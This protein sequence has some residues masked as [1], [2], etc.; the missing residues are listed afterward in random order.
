MS[1]TSGKMRSLVCVLAALACVCALTHAA[2]MMSEHAIMNANLRAA[3]SAPQ[4]DGR[5]DP[6]EF[7]I[8]P[9]DLND[10]SSDPEFA[11]MDREAAQAEASGEVESADID[12]ALGGAGA[13]GGGGR[14][15]QASGIDG[16]SLA[17]AL[18]GLDGEAS[19]ADDDEQE[20]VSDAASNNLPQPA[21]SPIGGVSASGANAAHIAMGVHGNAR[22]NGPAGVYGAAGATR[23]MGN[24]ASAAAAQARAATNW[25][26]ANWDPRTAASLAYAASAAGADASDAELAG[27]SEMGNGFHGSGSQVADLLVDEPH[28]LDSNI[29]NA[30][31]TLSGAD[32]QTAAG[33]HHHHKHYVHGKLEMGAHT[34]KKGSFK[35]HDKH[36]VGGKGRR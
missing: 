9:S 4:E 32:M 34:G 1:T 3:Q 13:G 26:Q 8:G 28:S 18:T 20:D 30:R 25:R 17:S 6:E 29:A 11:A 19:G 15:A 5:G 2:P 35:W 14:D 36:P 21:G 16:E 27:G 23:R 22:D 10:D 31:V 7:N 12:G 33:H 24:A